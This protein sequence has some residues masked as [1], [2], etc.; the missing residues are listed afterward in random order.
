MGR[1]I[2]S[3]IIASLFLVSSK[4]FA[5]ETNPNE[6]ATVALCFF[7][8]KTQHAGIAHY[9][10]VKKNEHT[11]WLIF[12]FEP[13]G[14]VIISA[15]K[16]F[17]PVLAWSPKGE[18][19]PENIP[20]NCSY[21][22]K[23][24]EK[25]I[26]TV[27]KSPELLT[28]N[29]PAW[30]LILANDF[31]NETRA[32]QPL[33]TAKWDQGKFYNTM[34]P[35]ESNG[36]DGHTPVGCVA[37][38]MAQVIYYYRFPERGNGI[39]SYIPPYNNGVYGV[40]VAD[41]G[42]TFY[43][44]DEMVDRC[45]TY[46]P[47]VA[48]LS[49]HCAVAVNMKFSPTSSGASTSDIVPA[50]VN[51][52]NYSPSA[53]LAL[54]Q[55]AGNYEN[56]RQKLVTNLDN[57]RP[58]IYFSS[59]GYIG[60]AY[61]CD[62]YSDSTHFH[63]NWGWSGNHNGYYYINEL[64]PGGIDLTQSQGG[65]FDIYPDTTTFDY[66][67]F[68]QEQQTLSSSIGSVTDGSGSQ[69]YQPEANCSWLIMPEDP[70]ITNIQIDFSLFD[71]VGGTDYLH[72]YDGE[73]N[74]APLVG[75]FTGTTLPPVINSSQPSLYL[76]IETIGPATGKGFHANYHAYSLPFC[77]E[78]KVINTSAG[79]LNDGS[80]FFNYSNNMDCNWL[81][82]PEVPVFDSVEKMFI[83]FTR[84]N[85][86]LGDT[87][88]VYDGKDAFSPLLAKL[89][90][91][92]LP[93]QFTSS[94]QHLFLNFRTNESD[95]A[96]GWEIKYTGIPPVYCSDTTLITAPSGII[97]DG[98]GAKH[99]NINTFCHWKIHI[100]EAEFVTLEFTEVDMEL[101]YDYILIR[102]LNKPYVAPVRITGNN[103]PPPFTISSNNVLISFLSDSR[104][105][106]FG[107]EL[108]YHA[109]AGQIGEQTLRPVTFYPNP[110]TDVLGI[111]QKA[112]LSGVLSLGIF[113]LQGV[114]L[115][116]EIRSEME[117]K[118]D[119]KHFPKGIYLLE[120]NIENQI[121]YQKIVKL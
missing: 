25:Q 55:S 54:R 64:I 81:F 2:L 115:L 106:G 53:H 74:A 14:F 11:L 44:W 62:G 78:L 100:S 109:S 13:E 36:Y 31:E 75:S 32:V 23:W 12:N 66:P 3:V 86:E 39:H 6:A 71:L 28:S 102:D 105:N 80:D 88:C 121:Y 49:Y 65:I 112:N 114:E 91:N 118:V 4:T 82:A 51:Y 83:Q 56:W 61:V 20:E 113:N 16:R 60:H 1:F 94:G 37:T 84:F 47:A 59:S 85:L 70:V 110:V 103:T 90:G 63:F 40:Q 79:Y 104:D 33:V 111:C 93:P 27:L 43:S 17:Y 117:F 45:F 87:L 35:S 99:Y 116:R 34:C 67:I 97:E 22:L 9:F 52:F 30:E 19:S 108:S 72:V 46:N 69:N 38:A 120:F 57:N 119:I 68:C 26:L 15:D 18:F 92:T 29:H 58:V 8:N 77:H 5:G 21:W 10:P 7:S 24:Y 48:E 42:N 95:S 73:S 101:N 107:W 89:T 41:F 50:M 76:Q 98:S 96:S